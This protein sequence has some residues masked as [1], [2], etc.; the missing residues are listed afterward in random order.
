MGLQ[1]KGSMFVACFALDKVEPPVRIESKPFP[2]KKEAKSNVVKRA[3]DHFG[4]CSKLEMKLNGSAMAIEGPCAAVKQ[5]ESRAVITDVDSGDVV[6]TMK[7]DCITEELYQSNSSSPT[8]ASMHIV[9]SSNQTTSTPEVSS[10]SNAVTPKRGQKRNF[11]EMRLESLEE[12]VLED[13][14]IP[15]CSNTSGEAPQTPAFSAREEK[16]S[17]ISTPVFSKPTTPKSDTKVPSEVT[18]TS[19]CTKNNIGLLYE[20]LQASHQISYP[21]RHMSVREKTLDGAS[22]FVA[23]FSFNE[24]TIEG[25]FAHGK[26]RARL[27]CATRALNVRFI[28]CI[29]FVG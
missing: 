16:S 25:D 9:G 26:K 2:S 3:L 27:A 18:L 19:K 15:K 6:S 8:N 20:F 10:N 24:H 28:L 17:T 22:G 21:A 12:S 5:I 14:E 23:T 11:E 7:V 13:G 1:A 4:I 29:R